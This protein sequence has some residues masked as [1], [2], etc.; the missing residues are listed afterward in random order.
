MDF[1]KATNSAHLV[2]IMFKICSITFLF[3][4]IQLLFYRCILDSALNIK[5]D[6]EANEIHF[7]QVMN[8]FL[9]QG[10]HNPGEGRL[11]QGAGYSIST[12]ESGAAGD[13]KASCN[14]QPSIKNADIEFCMQKPFKCII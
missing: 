9:V 3:C 13:S 4:K 8:V 6:I 10:E 1:T 11:C 5:K 7:C 2:D 14:Q 12:R